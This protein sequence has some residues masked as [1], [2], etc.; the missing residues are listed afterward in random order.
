[1]VPHSVWLSATSQCFQ[2][3]CIAGMETVSLGGEER[4]VGGAI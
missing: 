2:S 3:S 4:G 1:M